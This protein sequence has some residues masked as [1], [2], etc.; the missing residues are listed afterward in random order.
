AF[1]H[2]RRI[3]SVVGSIQTVYRCTA[4]AIALS[5]CSAPFWNDVRVTG[6]YFWVTYS[7]NARFARWISLSFLTT[8]AVAGFLMA[9]I[10]IFNVTGPRPASLIVCC[11]TSKRVKVYFV[12]TILRTCVYL[13]NGAV[14]FVDEFAVFRVGKKEM[15]MI[16]WCSKYVNVIADTFVLFSA[17]QEID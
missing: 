15:V 2:L 13:Y 16:G 8:Q 12:L 14:L 6:A 5:C 7:G 9:L 17:F 1:S 3:P 10:L 4:L 11:R